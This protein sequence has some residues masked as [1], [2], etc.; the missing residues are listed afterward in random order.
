MQNSI[1][2]KLT[3][4]RIDEIFNERDLADWEE[5]IADYL[6]LRKN[7][8][9]A[10]SRDRYPEYRRVFN[11]FYKVR[12][13]NEWQTEFLYPLLFRCAKDNDADFAKILHALAKGTAQLHASFASKLAAT[14]NPHLPVIDRN[15]LSYLDRKLPQNSHDLESRIAVVIELHRNM[16]L[17]FEAFIRTTKG[18][19]LTQRFANAYPK[20]EIS[21]MKMLDFVLWK[22]GGNKNKK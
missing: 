1:R 15:V 21:D 22:S 19:H 14:V 7:L 3:K 20:A 2:I 18:K 11:R 6:Y 8:S 16:K 4:E 17:A 12:M 9:Q 13:R 5:N 10:S